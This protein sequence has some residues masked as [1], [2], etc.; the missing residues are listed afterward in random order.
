MP[1]VTQPSPS[2]QPYQPLPPVMGIARPPKSSGGGLTSLLAG[3]LAV[4]AA[5]LAFGGSFAAITTFR[6][7]FEGGGETTVNANNVSWWS[8]TDA[9][10]SSPF[11][12]ESL[13]TWLVLL[14]AA[15]VLLIGA[16]F[17]C[18]A[19][20]TRSP[21]AVTGS[22]SLVTAGIGVLTGAM[23]LETLLVLRQASNYN[24]RE[25]QAGESLDFSVGLGFVLPLCGLAVGLIAVV[26]AHVGQGGRRTEPSTPRMGF[27][28]PYGYPPMQGGAPVGAAP[29]GAPGGAAPAG[30]AA[31]AAPAGAAP[32]MGTPAGAGVAEAGSP[33]VGSPAGAAAAA[34]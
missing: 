19:S 8:L 22:R 14:L 21:G 24:S 27:P 34:A 30:V 7:T 11:D 13:L 5:G 2:Y 12:K 1:R 16:A 6:N 4:V 31:G 25:L 28:A 23:L 3:I 20:S 32:A 9:G 18:A 17:A 33:V 26:L 10:S 29:A 15:V